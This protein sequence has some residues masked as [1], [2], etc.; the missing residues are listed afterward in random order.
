[1]VWVYWVYLVDWLLFDV[2]VVVCVGW[3]GL[4]VDLYVVVFWEW[5]VEKRKGWDVK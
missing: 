2:E 3:V 4:W 1:M 5:C